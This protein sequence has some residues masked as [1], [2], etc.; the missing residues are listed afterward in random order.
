MH[1]VIDGNDREMIRI[2]PPN[3]KAGTPKKNNEGDNVVEPI[4]HRNL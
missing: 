2:K 3:L 4:I 1:A